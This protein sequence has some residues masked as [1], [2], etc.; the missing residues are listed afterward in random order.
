M[1]ERE[2]AYI[3]LTT[4]DT[5]TTFLLISKE[6]SKKKICSV[7]QAATRPSNLDC[8]TEILNGIFLSAITNE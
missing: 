4:L 3:L 6:I 5:S 8:A 7:I 1:N 2:R